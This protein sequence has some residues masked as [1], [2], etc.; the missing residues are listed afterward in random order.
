MN[1]TPLPP[2]GKLSAFFSRVENVRDKH[3]RP[4][5]LDAAL[6]LL[7][8]DELRPAVEAIRNRYATVL[9]T[10]GSET[11]AKKA[12]KDMKAALPAFMFAGVFN[13]RG[14][15]NLAQPSG[16]VVA[17]FDHL[18]AAAQASLRSQLIA[19]PAVVL[20]YSSPSSG[21]KAVYRARPDQPHAA[22]FAAVRNHVKAR[23]SH[24][25]D[26]SGK[27]PERLCFASW[28]PDAYYNPNSVP[29]AVPEFSPAEIEIPS[30]QSAF[31][32]T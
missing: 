19:D 32:L 21:I 26:P 24:D 15:T 9:H 13:G 27:N 22:N 16:L 31:V 7:R 28:D 3:P 17:D 10:A 2:D 6:A 8:S 11:E 23:T 14:D 5:T 29:V 12:V 20:M 1:T 18:D 30:A 25:I 4:C